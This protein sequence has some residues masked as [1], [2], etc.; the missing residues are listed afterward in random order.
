MNGHRVGVGGAVYMAAVLEYLTAELIEIAG[1][2]ARGERKKRITPFAIK[3]A[4]KGDEELSKLLN[5]VTIGQLA[6]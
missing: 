6:D 2:D 4:L 3:R 5:N 1:N